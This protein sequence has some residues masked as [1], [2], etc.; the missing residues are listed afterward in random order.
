MACWICSGMG[1]LQGTKY[2]GHYLTLHMKWVIVLMNEYPDVMLYWDRYRLCEIMD[3]RTHHP[4]TSAEL[5]D[6]AWDDDGDE[7]VNA[8]N[9]SQSEVILYGRRDAS[10]RLGIYSDIVPSR[11]GLKR[12]CP[13]SGRDSRE[14]VEADAR[15][16]SLQQ[17]LAVVRC[18]SSFFTSLSLCWFVYTMRFFGF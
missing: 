9:I 2:H 1:K 18:R 4:M 5:P 11:I 17:E 14:V 15:Q 16:L 3:S 13:D 8:A 12:P 7:K 6:D 10:L